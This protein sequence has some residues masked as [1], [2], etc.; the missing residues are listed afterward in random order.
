MNAK[1]ESHFIGQ[2]RRRNRSLD[3][4]IS[5]LVGGVPAI[6]LQVSGA[7]PSLCAVTRGLLSAAGEN[8]SSPALWGQKGF[9]NPDL[10]QSPGER[11]PMGLGQPR[12]AWTG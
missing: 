9:P 11:C 2:T 10:G 3:V 12:R 6:S 5:G 4:A 7:L 8:T 1:G